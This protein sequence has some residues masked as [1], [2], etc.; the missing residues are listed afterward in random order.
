ME[1]FVEEEEYDPTAKTQKINT[2]MYGNLLDEE[3]ENQGKNKKD[4]KDGKFKSFI[5]KT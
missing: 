5:K 2:D 4:K 1:I 3:K